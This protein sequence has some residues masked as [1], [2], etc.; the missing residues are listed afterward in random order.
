MET[1]QKDALGNAAKKAADC[2][3]CIE[4]VMD[5]VNEDESIRAVEG[6]RRG[7][8]ADLTTPEIRLVRKS[9]GNVGRPPSVRQL[10][11]LV[12]GPSPL[13][14]IHASVRPDG[15]N[16]VTRGLGGVVKLRQLRA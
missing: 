7:E 16:A 13:Q 12:R 9:D 4:D 1:K 3:G 10:H 6:E 14:K 8:E 15:G 11:V 5:G 2:M